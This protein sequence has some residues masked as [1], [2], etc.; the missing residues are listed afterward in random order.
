MPI[1]IYKP[2]EF[3]SHHVKSIIEVVST[4]IKVDSIKTFIS[5]THP[6]YVIF[7]ITLE[8]G[9][10][11]YKVTMM[12]SNGERKVISVSSTHQETETITTI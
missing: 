10:K 1:V 5:E 6:T 9:G 12:E 4:K 7:Q 2:E 3:S 11:P 8:S